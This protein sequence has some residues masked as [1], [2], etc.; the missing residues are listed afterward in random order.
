MSKVTTVRLDD[1]LSSKLDEL[2]TALD[3]PKSWL[4]EQAISSYVE[5]QSWQVEAISEAL[6]RYQSGQATLIPH[7]QVMERIE[8]KLKD[9]R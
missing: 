8:A 9:R 1:S 6:A 7:E 4:I 2:A 3:R 5:E